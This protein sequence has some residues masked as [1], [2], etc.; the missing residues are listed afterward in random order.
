MGVGWLHGTLGSQ[1]KETVGKPLE[2]AW[3]PFRKLSE[4]EQKG[5]WGLV[6][7][8]ILESLHR[9]KVF[10]S[11]KGFFLWSHIPCSTHTKGE[12]RSNFPH[13]QIVCNR[14]T[15]LRGDFPELA[16]APG[17]PGLTSLQ[18]QIAGFVLAGHKSRL[19]YILL[20]GG[21]LVMFTGSP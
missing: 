4:K 7:R 20:G 2:E 13:R 6:V 21:S 5:A 3:H 10:Q 18:V 16:Q 8:K 14:L 1:V 19:P 11:L 9:Y 15:D 12:Q 17:P